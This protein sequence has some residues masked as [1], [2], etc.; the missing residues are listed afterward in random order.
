MRILNLGLS[1]TLKTETDYKVLNKNKIF[2]DK[3]QWI[4]VVLRKKTRIAGIAVQGQAEVNNFVTKFK[5]KYGN[6]ATSLSY[7]KD[8]SGNVVVS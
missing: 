8:D 1:Q 2:T 6:A 3:Y 5:I 7:I 4:Q